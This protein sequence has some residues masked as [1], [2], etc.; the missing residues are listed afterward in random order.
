MIV[1][2]GQGLPTHLSSNGYV[3]ALMTDARTNEGWIEDLKS[4]GPTQD[5]ALKD[6]RSVI[7]KGLPYAISSWLSPGDPQFDDLIE[8][9]AQ[10]T[11]L[12]VLSHMDTFEGRS[13]FTTW[14]LKIA[15]R[16][17]ITELRRKRWQDTSLDGF[18][19]AEGTTIGSKLMLDNGPSPELTTEQGQLLDQ[20]QQLID[21]E[22]T[23]KQRKA[24]VAIR[25]H[26]MP[27]EEVARRMDMSR[28]ALY[29]LLHDAR[30]R[31]KERM[32]REG[33]TAEELL[34]SFE[35]G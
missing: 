13:K 4:E 7:M 11:L 2:I 29:K 32:Q 1:L 19:E 10:E 21:E 24:M 18:L 31:L 35:A 28:N 34:A 23:E 26:G 33:L 6:L 3:I 14:V 22:L 9:V 16:L 25:I 30:N 20:V 5:E 27:M 12:R 15:V 8:E 17:A